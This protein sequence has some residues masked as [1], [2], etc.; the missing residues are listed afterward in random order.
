MKSVLFLLISLVLFYSCEK[1]ADIIANADVLGK[2]KLVQVL[3]DPGDGS[4]QFRNVDNDISI[5][6]HSDGTVSSNG[7]L[8]NISIVPDGEYYGT[9]SLNDS[10]ITPDGCPYPQTKLSFEITGNYM[11]IHYPC[12]EACRSRFKK[13]DNYFDH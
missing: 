6:F 9:Y 10:T 11:I 5:V 13:V 1:S 3:A 4:G 2:W 12:I 7:M 8:C